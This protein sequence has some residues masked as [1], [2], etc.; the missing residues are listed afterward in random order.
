VAVSPLTDSYIY[1]ENIEFK[2]IITWV[3]CEV[4]RFLSLRQKIWGGGDRTTN[5]GKFM[6]WLEH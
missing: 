6:N 3:K 2:L 1:S 4:A 5:W